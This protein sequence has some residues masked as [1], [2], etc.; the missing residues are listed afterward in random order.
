M[1]HYILCI[2]I[3]MHYILYFVAV[4]STDSCL[5]NVVQNGFHPLK[6]RS[7]QEGK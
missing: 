2:I 3:F 1:Y 5:C 7:K 4:Q 6:I